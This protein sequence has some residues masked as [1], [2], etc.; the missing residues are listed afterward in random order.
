[1]VTYL[2]GGKADG[3]QNS[4]HG[5][6]SEYDFFFLLLLFFS[7]LSSPSIQRLYIHEQSVDFGGRT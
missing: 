5:L 6:F 4:L 7:S 1:M 2:L 3:R